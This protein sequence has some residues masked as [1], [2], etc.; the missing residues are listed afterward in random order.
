[1][2]TDP[3]VVI[4]LIGGIGSGKSRVA[5]ELARHGG[6]IVSG[7]AAG[8]DVLKQ[9]AVRDQLV[10]RWGKGVLNE[11]GELDRS[12]VGA[13]V[14]ANP[15]ELKALEAVV[16]PVIKQRLGEEIAAAQADPAVKFIVV[17]AAI[18]L[19]AGWDGACDKL[20]FVD[21]PQE[22]RL[23]RLAEQRGWDA[24]EVERRERVQMSLAEKRKRA[25]ATLKNDGSPEKLARGVE[26][27]LRRLGVL[28]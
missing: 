1:M 28:V 8:H 18:M 21:A 13:I 25:D 22:V 17:D 3:R 24:A 23:H 10:Q 6:R 5:A 14:F 15:E 9:P 20:V 7:D 27:L 12:K 19:E 4:G 11:K 26:V 16:H 2:T